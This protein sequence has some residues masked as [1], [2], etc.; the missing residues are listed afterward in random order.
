MRFKKRTLLEL[1]DLVCGNLGY[2]NPSA[3]QNP[4][5][6]PYRSSKYITEFFEDLE[7][8]HVHDGS[9]RAAW[10]PDVLEELR[11]EPHQAHLHPD[12]CLL[13]TPQNPTNH[14]TPLYLSFPHKKTSTKTHP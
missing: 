11:A 8:P 4:R 6:F 5:Y 2:D 1:A 14:N 7:L 10:L 13:K 12:T 9:T 3:G